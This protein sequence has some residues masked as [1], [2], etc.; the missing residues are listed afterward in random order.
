MAGIGSYD[1]E[2]WTDLVPTTGSGDP[3]DDSKIVYVSSSIGSNSYNGLSGTVDGGGVGPKLTIQAGYDLL[4]NGYPDWL[5]LKRGDVW[6]AEDLEIGSGGPLAGVSAAEPIVITAYGTG[7]RP[8]IKNGKFQSFGGVFSYLAITSLEFYGTRMDPSHADYNLAT[9]RTTGIFF[10]YATGT[11]YQYILIEDCRVR[12][13]AGIGVYMQAAAPQRYGNFYFRRNT[14]EETQTGLS[15]PFGQTALIEDNIFVRNGWDPRDVFIHSIYAKE[16]KNLTARGNLLA[17]S[18]NHGIKLS[19]DYINGYSDFDIDDNFFYYSVLGLDWSG[20]L[21]ASPTIKIPTQ[22]NV[23]ATIDP[24]TTAFVGSVVSGTYSSVQT[25]NG[26]FHTID[27]AANVIDV[28]YGWDM[29]LDVTVSADQHYD[30]GHTATGVIIAAYLQGSGDEM[31]V[32]AWNYTT[33]SWDIIG[34]LTGADT[35][36]VVTQTLS[37]TSHHTGPDGDAHEGKVYIRLTTDSTTPSTLAVDRLVLTADPTVTHRG[38]TVTS[39]I[40]S[41]MDKNPGYNQSI[42]TYILNFADTTFDGNLWVHHTSTNHT[43]VVLGVG[44]PDT[45]HENI[46]ITN[47]IIWDWYSYSYINNGHY[48]VAYE[49]IVDLVYSGNTA[50]DV[51]ES[52]F[53][54]T[55]TYSDTTRSIETYNSVV[56][57]GTEDADEFLDAA[58]LMSKG[59]WDSRYTATEL[60]TWIRA[61]FD[62]IDHNPTTFG[63]DTT[64]ECD[65][66]A[67]YVTGILSA[68]DAVDGMTTPNF[69][70]T[71]AASHGEGSINSTTG[72]WSY[73]PDTD[74]FGSDSFTVRVTDDL[75]NHDT[76]VITITVNEVGGSS[77]TYYAISA[78]VLT[79]VFQ[80]GG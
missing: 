12:W 3:S 80:T 30:T 47:N 16:V 36:T 28:V 21:A 2:G 64:G 50:E 17:Y 69:T 59:D 79:Y 34:T 15:C 40:F 26:T 76:Q 57:G 62:I 6:D 43:G 31:R 5:R 51:D 24:N 32:K 9:D 19:A 66:N 55:D 56:L 45:Y 13:N 37:L 48:L 10:Q 65:E 22:S 14:I 74:F 8:L 67:D 54:S 53:Q 63:G 33:D 27:D 72:A 71:G 68:S 78:G 4:R 25:T 60:N 58:V 46:T 1:A 70:V 41:E 61:G 42:A 75:G 18:G 7:A 20:R 73:T 38:G 49:H 11:N 23:S 52:L 39:N 77:P 35:T 44:W 29:W